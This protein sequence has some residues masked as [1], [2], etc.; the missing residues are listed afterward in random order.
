MPRPYRFEVPGGI[1]HVATRSVHERQSFGSVDDRKDFL[2]IL[3]S[4]VEACGWLCKG[5]C[6]MSS[7]YHLIVE[8]RVPNLSKGMQLLNGRYAQR[9]NWR[10]GRRGH[11]FGGR[12]YSVLVETDAHLFE[13]LRYVALNPVRAGLCETP[14]DW[15]WS[16]FRPTAGLD[17]APRF[18]DC[19]GV[20]ALFG[21]GRAARED[22]RR[23]VESMRAEDDFGVIRMDGI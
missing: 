18:L 10:Y 8:T 9:F 11:L 5:Y 7:H 17:P 22:F 3:G 14:G 20:L 12:F 21:T 6:L 13:A 23:F 2:D 15:R 4:V 16:S 1:F 19:A